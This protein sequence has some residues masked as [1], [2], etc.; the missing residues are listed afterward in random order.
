ML[1]VV[2]R[3]GNLKRAARLS[4]AALRQR[5]AS[6]ILV[7]IA[8]SILLV[9]GAFEPFENQ[10]TA[11]RAQILDR[12]PTGQ[13]AIVEIDARSLAE[14]SNWPWSRRYHADVVNR[15]H[16]AGAEIIAFDVDFSS[17]SEPSGD[18]AFAEALRR[19]EPVILPIFQQR[20]SDQSRENIVI[21][22]RPAPIFDTAWVGG[23]NI[24]P[25]P[26][27]VVRE[28][29]AAT[30]IGG[31]IRPSISTLLAESDV[32]GDRSF[33]P[34]W[35]IDAQRIPRF[36]F[37]DV[38]KGRIPR[39]AIAGKRI[40]VGATAIELGDRY[41]V[42]RLGSVPG[43]IVQAL[44]T[45]SLLQGRALTR[46]GALPTLAGM[47]AVTLLL[48][49]GRFRRFT[50]TFPPAALAILLLLAIG[51][52]AVQT[53]WPLS[54]DSAAL[55]C[56][57]LACVALRVV[58]EIRRRV[59][60]KALFD[61]ETYLPNRVALEAELATVEAPAPVLATAAIERFDGIRDAIG[62]EAVTELVCQVAARI[63]S[64]IEGS[65][66]RTAPD[67]LAW[68]QPGDSNIAAGA[69]ILSITELFREPV[70]TREG[71]VDVR[72]TIGLD[73]DP[74]ANGIVPKIERA[75][76]A[77]SAARAAG[78]TCHWYQGADPV[79]RRQ[80]S[81]MGEL[82][83]GMAAGEVTVA[84]QPKLDLKSGKITHAE[85]LVRWNHPVDG[86]IPPDRFIPLAESSGVISELTDFV[87]RTVVADCARLRATG[88]Q[89]CAAVNISATDI[90]APGFVDKVKAVLGEF[91]VAAYILSLEV[92]ESAIIR[93]TATAISVLTEL[94]ELGIRLSIDDY[95]TGQSTLS[96]L[97]QLPVHELKI[98]K[99]FVTSICDNQNDEIMVRS[100]ISLAHELGLQVVAEG[101]EDEASTRLL[102]S[103]GCDYAQGYFV[104]K[105]M[106]FDDLCHL[107]DGPSQ[108]VKVA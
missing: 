29:P 102:K 47:I 84:Y 99:S 17:V 28:Y 32:L 41:V 107:S 16:S 23:V 4:G 85:A 53:R 44:A 93:S 8:T 48:G 61:A 31:E 72:L 56:S 88:R 104:G 91:E 75:L 57:A 21:K 36:S 95:G 79:V 6:A 24:F 70:Q 5:L 27:G 96:Y 92:T 103:L 105:P 66:Y 58:G 7:I 15:L 43:V 77:I 46:S 68:V 62:I 83:R 11:L 13:V 38:V 101:V 69:L 19:A 18:R 76:A 63:Q 35:S 14:L 82:R 20:A 78:D 25:G 51:P 39:E 40:L 65:V 34:D 81:M 100:T 90:A 98:D 80:L 1:D 26:D 59:A 106:A 55:L 3:S 37:V 86:P 33:Q 71:G 64:R 42:P 89:M 52:I 10:L 49:V 9:A 45:E 54:I 22:S 74:I 50:R 30:I 108:S 73:R 60:L 94:R 97:K 2:E 12:A 87:L 67:I